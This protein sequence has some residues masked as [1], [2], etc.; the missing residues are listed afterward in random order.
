MARRAKHLAAWREKNPPE[1]QKKEAPAAA[2][3]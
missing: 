3:K 2:K 1:I